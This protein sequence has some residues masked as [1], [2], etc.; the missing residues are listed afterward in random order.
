MSAPILCIVENPNTAEPRGEGKFARVSRVEIGGNR[1]WNLQFGLIRSIHR[2]VR[3]VGDPVGDSQLLGNLHS[4]GQEG[5][6]SKG[7]LPKYIYMSRES[8]D[9]LKPL[10]SVPVVEYT[11][12]PIPATA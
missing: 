9:I 3:T 1:F 2:L 10:M 12:E 4:W 11:L 6:N 8:F 5:K 7:Q